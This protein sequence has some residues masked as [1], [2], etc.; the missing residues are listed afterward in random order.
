MLTQ[1]EVNRIVC[2]CQEN[3]KTYKEYLKEH[4]IPAWKFYAATKKYLQQLK[5]EVPIAH[6]MYSLYQFVLYHL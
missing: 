1:E 4:G 6:C 5:E 3:D 2:F